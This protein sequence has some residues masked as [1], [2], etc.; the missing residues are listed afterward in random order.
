MIPVLPRASRRVPGVSVV[1]TF[2]V[3]TGAAALVGCAHDPATKGFAA[4][5]G[6]LARESAPTSDWDFAH[7]ATAPSSKPDQV[8]LATWYGEKFHGKPTANGERFDVRGMTAAHLTLPFGTWVEVRRPDTGRAVRVRI[9]DRGP[10]GDRR[11]I[12][13]LSRAAAEALDIIAA[14]TVRVELRVVR[15]P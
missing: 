8:G 2:A 3:F 1:R 13:D 12:I 6:S 14:G 10:H 7:G 11:K 9:N 15:T 4:P 5:P